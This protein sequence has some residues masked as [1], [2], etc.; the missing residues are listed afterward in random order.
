MIQFYCKARRDERGILRLINLFGTKD[1]IKCQK[2]ASL[3]FFSCTFLSS[4]TIC[5]CQFYTLRLTKIEGGKTVIFFDGWNIWLTEFITESQKT[6]ECLIQLLGHLPVIL[7]L[8]KKTPSRPI[9]LFSDNVAVKL[10]NTLDSVIIFLQSCHT[11][12]LKLGYWLWCGFRN[13]WVSHSVLLL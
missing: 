13:A 11:Q 4:C 6:K 2:S 5:S 1:A 7:V 8:Q 3:S 9:L 10:L 12:I